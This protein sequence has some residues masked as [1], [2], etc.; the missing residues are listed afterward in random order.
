MVPTTTLMAD[1]ITTTV[2]NFKTFTK[3]E[4]E[5]DKTVR[6]LED[7]AEQDREFVFTSLPPGRVRN[8]ILK[9]NCIGRDYRVFVCRLIW[10]LP[11][12]LQSA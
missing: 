10:V 1:D 3:E 12:P 5:E 4:E 2:E 7:E 9:N 11:T 8:H 6:P